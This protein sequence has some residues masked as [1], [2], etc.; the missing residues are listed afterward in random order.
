M[1]QKRMKQILHE[2]KMIRFLKDKTKICEQDFLSQYIIFINS[3][4]I[5]LLSS[6]WHGP[7]SW[8]K[9]FEFLELWLCYTEPEDA[10]KRQ[11]RAFNV[12]SIAESKR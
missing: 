3:V 6:F 10:K 5:G 9:A 8:I 11:Q 1:E 7:N 12:I 2:E 4:L